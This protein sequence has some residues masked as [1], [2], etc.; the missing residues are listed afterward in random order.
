MK[1]FAQVLDLKNDPARIE[2]YKRWHTAVWPEVIRG[3]RA[4]GLRKMKIF[5]LGTHLFMYYEAPDDFVPDRDYQKYAQ[6]PRVREW[7]TLM[8]GFQQPVAEA[9]QGKGEWW[10]DMQCVFDLESQP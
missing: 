8:R 6:D 4:I 1:A 3:L 10:T 7:D 2:E 9:S 5:L